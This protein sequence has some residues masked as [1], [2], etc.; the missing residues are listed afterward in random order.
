[1]LARGPCDA[2]VLPSNLPQLE[3]GSR[4]RVAHVGSGARPER[5]LEDHELVVQVESTMAS[6]SKFLFRK[7][8]AKYEFFKNPMNFFPE[9]MVTWCQQS[10]GSHTQLLQVLGRKR[11]LLEFLYRC[12]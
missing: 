9:Q 5:C 8:Y 12:S 6:E 7:N 4:M 11:L 2:R 10:N 3:S 1:M